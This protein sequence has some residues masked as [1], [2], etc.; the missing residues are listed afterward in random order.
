MSQETASRSRT[1]AGRQASA[2]PGQFRLPD[3]S[4]CM[5]HDYP[6]QAPPAHRIPARRPTLQRRV[7]ALQAENRRLR[8]LIMTDDLTGIFNRRYFAS[9]LRDVLEAPPSTTGIALCLFDLDNFKEVNDRHG[10]AVG[11]H[12]LRSVAQAAKQRLR[13]TGDCVCRIGGDEF[14]VIYTARSA[15][16]AHDVAASIMHAVQELGR[17]DDAQGALEV[18]ASFG[19]I[20]L[21]PTEKTSWRHAYARADHCL[22]EAKRAGK[23]A[24]VMAEMELAA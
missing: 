2:G 6:A 1:G 21:D 13:R 12:L 20:W 19:L 11:D 3:D 7:H 4:K 15:E 24:L 9:R 14:A 22:Y 10:H 16:A 18:N 23:G 8:R 17:I 5:T